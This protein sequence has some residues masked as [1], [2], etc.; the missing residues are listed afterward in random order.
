MN[1]GDA[2]QKTPENNMAQKAQQAINEIIADLKEIRAS[3]TAEEINQKEQQLVNQILN[4]YHKSAEKYK[5]AEAQEKKGELT[6]Q[7]KAEKKEASE[8]LF[9]TL[10]QAG[11]LADKGVT[12]VKDNKA[13]DIIKELVKEKIT[14]GEALE[15]QKALDQWLLGENPKPIV[16]SEP[17]QEKSDFQKAI[18]N[19]NSQTHDKIDNSLIRSSE[20]F[21]KTHQEMEAI[22]KGT[23][24]EQE[25]E[26]KNGDEVEKAI[27]NLE[28][29]GSKEFD[30]MTQAE[31]QTYFYDRREYYSTRFTEDQ[32]ELIASFYSPDK[33]VDYMEKMTEGLDGRKD[34]H[35]HKEISIEKDKI[36][37][38]IREYY[39]KNKN[40]IN[41]AELKKEV[42][43]HWGARVSQEMTTKVSDVIN[44]LFLELQ[45]KPPHKFFE[46]V[47]QEDIFKGPSMIQKTIQRAINSLMNKV[48]Q[49]EQNKDNP[50]LDP[51]LRNL[52][53]R[54]EKL[55]LFRH[56][57]QEHYIDVRGEKGDRYPRIKP[58]AYE[59]DVSLSKFVEYVNMTF[60]HSV[61]TTE[62]LHNIKAMF[63]HPP[64]EKGFYGQLGGYAEAFKG[65]D[66]D[67]LMLLPDGKHIIE[68]YQLYE[69][70]IEEDFAS[71]DWRHRPDQF[72]NQLE[73]VNSNIEFQ[74]I[75]QLKDFFPDFTETRIINI[76]NAAVGISRGMF[77]SES[78][79]SAYADPVD[80]QGK[81]MVASYSTNDAG[82]LTAFNPMHVIMRWQGEHNVN[83]MYFMP[84][85]GEGR[86]WDHGKAWKNMA[87]YMNS[88]LA[89]RGRGEGSEKLPETFAD[90]LMNIGKIGGPG[91][92]KG[93]RMNYS[94]DGH[95]IYEIDQ[96]T[97]KTKNSLDILKSFKA[98]EAIGYEALSNFVDEKMLTSDIL[99]ATSGGSAAKR[100]EL[101]KYMYERYF[102]QEGNFDQYLEKMKVFGEKNA[103]EN[104]EK[105]TASGTS[106]EEMIQEETSKVFLGNFITHYVAE[107]FPTKFLRIDR[108]RFNENGVSRWEKVAKKLNWDI[109][110]FDT[111]MK[112]LN[113]AEML[114][115][116]E[117]SEQIRKNMSLDKN[118]PLFK[119]DN[120]P[121]RFTEETIRNLLSK[122]SKELTFKSESDINNVIELFRTIK[123]DLNEENFLN[124]PEQAFKRIKDYPFSFGLEDTDLPLVAFRAT[125]PRMI[126]RAIKDVGSIESEVMPWIIKMPQLLNQ[127]AINGKGDFSPI[128]EYMRKAQAAITD[129]NG[130]PATYDYMYKLASTAINYFKKDAWAK[131]LFGIFRMGMRNSIAAEMSGRSSAVWEWGARE[132]DQF[133]IA[134]DSN[135]LLKKDPY[136]LQKTKDGKFTGGQWEDRWIKLPFSKKPIKF[137]KKRHVDWEFNT[138]RLRNEHGGRY[139]DIAMDLIG[140]VI[141]L[142]MIFLLYE[143]LKKANEE[144]G[145][146][147]K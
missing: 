40:T 21:G 135:G 10:N 127:I 113:M 81:G 102:S 2:E 71:L 11:T 70:M 126:A 55:K 52:S 41:E 46:E 20:R 28:K 105:G 15:I 54:I 117:I 136:D 63:N 47:M 59:E 68:A 49:I 39:E 3:G 90:A 114:F 1:P 83:A 129:I 74:L 131:P 50:S 137:G 16:L 80:A 88:Y 120:L 99:K 130:V 87:K 7:Q 86:A 75:K 36:A 85:A 69:K 57:E 100:N 12:V 48:I 65:T 138:I 25:D 109:K 61:H 14:E 97:G 4:E 72:T 116:R 128:I 147:K 144:Q 35:S 122:N 67:G 77:L 146:K 125:G 98:M 30:H 19:L 112:D 143:Y 132:I 79:K 92:R 45:Q 115:R 32:L 66:I 64:G 9:K 133:C 5:D 60:N 44:Q 43:K 107:R 22:V 140:Q 73:R 34:F 84:I 108:N 118:M 76:A 26:Q 103:L 123:T 145:G 119:I 56:S 6:D 51:S 111:V 27:K 13:N 134:L 89:G 17:G 37:Q 139:R 8:S 104:V 96:E 91:I 82:S 38:E 18:D 94:L 24:Q 101:F 121:Y 23:S 53:N 106:W 33:F 124:N 31:A 93:W 62:F 29:S 58:I 78:E 142:A 42:D 95:Y 141:P 110:T